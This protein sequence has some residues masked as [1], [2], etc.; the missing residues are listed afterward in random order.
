MSVTA[1][2]MPRGGDAVLPVVGDLTH[3]P[4]VGLPDRARHRAGLSIGVQ[5][6]GAVDVARGS[7]DRL[8]ER[9]LG[10]QEPLLVGVENG[11]ERDLRHVEALPEQVDA[12][13][14][15]ELAPGEGRG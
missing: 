5:D 1:L 15:V 13:E 12:D 8:D 2:R 11:D 9:P 4:P 10:A 7:A 14:N 6:G 3:A